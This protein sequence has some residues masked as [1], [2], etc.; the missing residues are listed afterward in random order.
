[1]N[2]K[3][4][5]VG[6]DLHKSQ[7]TTCVRE[8]GKE[9]RY[10]Q[11]PTT[12]EGYQKF[13][14]EVRNWEEQGREVAAAVESTGNTRYFKRRLSGAGVEV[15]IINPQRFKVVSQSV[16]KTDKYDAAT[17]A[18]FLEADMLPEAKLCSEE[19]EQQRRLLKGRAVVVQ[20][21][22]AVKN[23]VH[24][25]L[26][27]LGMNDTKASLQSKKGR[28]RVLD[29]LKGTDY[30]LVVQPFMATVEAM[31]KL[32]KGYEAEL[33]RLTEKDPVVEL[34]RTIP[35]CG[36]ITAW[37]LR[38][39]TDDIGRFES[40]DKYAAYAGLVPWVQ[41]SNKT[42]HVGKITKR[43]PKELRTALVQLVMGILRM[44]KKTLGWRLMIR[45]EQQKR[46]KGS[47][48]SIISMA[49]KLAVIIWHM[50]KEGKGFDL[51]RMTD[52]KLEKK[53]AEMREGALRKGEGLALEAL[54]FPP[55]REITGVA[56]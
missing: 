4:Q 49:R 40:G 21:A 39:Y 23:Q 10:E 48:K 19:S 14:N 32:V 30:E 28:Q 54:S 41:A 53:A 3:K 44:K 33:Q 29:A 52:K 37:N 25:L 17:I 20:A 27:G 2:Q 22:V 9:N 51:V 36:P 7:F 26:T 47:G 56:G 55:G 31:E 24:G 46:Y 11:Y 13:L 1:M 35:G 42:V 15:R 16:H 50:L 5:Y 38:A 12:E 8:K 45:Y 6:V 18:E 34:L 43:G